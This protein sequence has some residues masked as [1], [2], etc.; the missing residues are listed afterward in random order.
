[1]ETMGKAVLKIWKEKVTNKCGSLRM[2]KYQ[3]ILL[4]SM[5]ENRVKS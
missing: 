2:S 3:Q 4:V 5:E 1:M